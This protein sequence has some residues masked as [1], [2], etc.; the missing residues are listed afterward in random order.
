MKK[1]RRHPLRRFFLII[2]VFFLLF[3]GRYLYISKQRV[4]QIN[5]WQ[6]QVE[7]LVKY[8]DIGEYRD[9]VL[10]II[11]TESKGNHVDIMQSSE[12]KYGKKDEINDTDE[13]LE[14]GIKFLSEA[15]HQSELLKTDVWTAVQAYN[16]G[17]N[18]ITYVSERGGNHTIELAEEY[19]K[20]ILAPAL[21]NSTGEEYRYLTPRSVIHNGGRLYRDGGNFFY[22]DIVKWNVRLLN[23]LT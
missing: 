8:Y 13:S 23:L 3:V 17:L 5:Q 10:G 2:F 21:G 19:S 18:Y 14:S 6:S 12:S 15:I 9:I 20:N 16:F 1:K 11:F 22:V 4:D 7:T